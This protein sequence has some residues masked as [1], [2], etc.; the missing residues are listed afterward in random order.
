MAL[1][2]LFEGVFK[3]D[4]KLATRNLA[5]RTRVYGEELKIVDGTEYRLWNP[6][7]SKLAAAALNG[8]KTMAITP[9][10][11]ILYLG[12]ANGTTCSHVSDIVGRDGSV[13]CVELSKRS[14]RDLLNVCETRENMLPIFAD[15]RN[16]EEYSEDVGIT[17][18]IYQDVSAQEQADILLK[19]GA[20]LASNGI[21]YVAIKSQS[22][23]VSKDPKLVFSEFIES[24]SKEFKA[25]EQIRLE[26]F[27]KMHL[28][29]VFQK[30]T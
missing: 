21:A 2:K 7:R 16:T 8:M 12:A 17:D 20:M 28:F 18:V 1:T 4:G 5:P 3:I 22:I 24:V 29:V 10:S 25:L 30:K 26:P 15:A 13:Y 6:Y 14:M 9:G 23:D 11:E 19:N 27:D